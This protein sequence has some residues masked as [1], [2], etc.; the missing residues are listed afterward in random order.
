MSDI[1]WNLFV[2]LRKELLEAQ[3]IRSQV[4]GFKITFVSA[5]IGLLVANLDSVDKALF[6]LPSFA[7]VFFDFI[8][9]SYSFSI[10]RIGSYTREHIEPFL[11]QK[12]A[13]PYDFV[14]WQEFL[15][16]PRT[17]QNL[18]LYGNM[19]ITVLTIAIGV[20]ALFFPFR[21]WISSG[22]FAALAI[23]IVMDVIA[24]RSP[25]RLGKLW[26]DKD[27]EAVDKTGFG[28]SILKNST[29]TE[30]ALKE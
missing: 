21:A 25:S 28:H 1:I 19:G 23:F 11:K 6:I 22:L 10:K 13:V 14:M 15:T 26:A 16:Q 2:E 5:S 17:R 8:I 30:D 3:K 18:S 12:G 27:F 4:I 7:A 9:Y 24:Y 20:I 29:E